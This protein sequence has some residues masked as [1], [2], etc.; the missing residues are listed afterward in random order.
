[1]LK[2]LEPLDWLPTAE[3]LP[4]SDEKPVDSELQ[5]LVADLLR[6]ILAGIF[7]GR[8][9]WFFGIDMGVYYSPDEPAIAPDGFLSI[10]VKSVKTKGLRTSYVLWEEDGVIPQ[11]VLEVVSKSYR[12]E[13]TSKKDLYRNLGVLYYV[14]YN[15]IRRRKNTL[16][17]Y[18][19][20]QEQY[21]P[22]IGNPVW[23]PEIGLGIG[24]DE[25]THQDRDREWLFWY[26][27]KG[28]RYLTPDEQIDEKHQQV[29]QAKQQT[30]QA[31]QQ[32][33]QAKQQTKL[34]Q[35]ELDQEKV[36]SQKFADRLRQLGI[37][38]DEL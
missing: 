12:G 15:P 16:E 20:V 19:L 17:V 37:N 9:D 38:L 18:R 30:Q 5:R 3:D 33:Q 10:G 25:Y 28:D 4:E 1:M 2:Y 32:T 24:K 8:T 23:M 35:E 14:V 7:K 22:V 6:N 11:F 36:R 13:Y 26:D 29:Q 31:K 27:E 34:I 21:V